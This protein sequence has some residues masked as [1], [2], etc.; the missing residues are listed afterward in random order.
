MRLH[1]MDLALV[2]LTTSEE[3]IKVFAKTRYENR[4][5]Y[6]GTGTD[7]SKPFFD[8]VSTKKKRFT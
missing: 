8:H 3:D 6:V 4:T 7:F 5:H 1:D 2:T